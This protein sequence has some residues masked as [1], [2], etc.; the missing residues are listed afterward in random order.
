MQSSD[1]LMRMFMHLAFQCMAGYLLSTFIIEMTTVEH[2]LVMTL[3]L[4]TLNGL[5]L[6][7]VIIYT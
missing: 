7:H 4:H 6:F 3:L 2:L 1:W 5:Y